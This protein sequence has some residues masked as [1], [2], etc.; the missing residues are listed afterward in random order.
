MSKHQ[1]PTKAE[2]FQED[3]MRVRGIEFASIGMMVEVN[4]ESGTIT[5]MNASANL[6]VKYAN[7]LKH[8][9]H[10]HSCHPTWRVK[11][12]DAAGELIAHF[13][14][15]GCVLRPNRAAA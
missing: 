7:V 4:G 2:I 15:S 8:G 1:K 10:D 9:K 6:T 14:D 12:F 5:G 13:D 11:Y 3:M